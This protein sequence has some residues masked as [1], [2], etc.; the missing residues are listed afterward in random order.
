MVMEKTYKVTQH[1]HE[2]FG[3]NL[4]LKIPHII[5]LRDVVKCHGILVRV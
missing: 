5:F 3:G 1:S 4:T 2:N